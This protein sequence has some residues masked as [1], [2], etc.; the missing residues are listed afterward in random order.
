MR[1]RICL[2]VL[3]ACLLAGIVSGC[4]GR[5]VSPA[6]NEPEQSG[7]EAAAAPVRD[8][9][10]RDEAAATLRAQIRAGKYTEVKP[11]AEALLADFPGDP[12]VKNLVFSSTDLVPYEGK[13]EHIFFH[14]LIAYKERALNGK[15][16][17]AGQDTY[18]VTVKEFNA[19]IAQMYEN[20]Y[21]LTSMHDLFS[22]T[23]NPDGTVTGRKKPV[24]LPRGKKPYIL[25]IDDMNYYEYMIEDGQVWKLVFDEN[26]EVAAY[27]KNLD[28][29]GEVRR[30]NA[31][32][33]LIDD[34]CK[35]HPDANFNGAKGLIG[36][37]GYE[38]VLGYRTNSIRYDNYV[39]EQQAVAPI[40]KK[41]KETGWDFASHSQGHRHTN[42]ASYEKIREDTDRWAFEVE[43][44]VGKTPIYIYPFG[45]TVK[46][47]DPKLAYFRKM[48]F[49]IFCGVGKTPYLEE[50]KAGFLKMDRRAI[51]GT[52][53]KSGVNN[54][55]L[56]VSRIIDKSFRKWA[57]N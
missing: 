52:T 25:S 14:P 19:T 23:T 32:V 31:I 1:K 38:G 4:S 41:L 48:G 55:L 42:S 51:D 12:V 54:N 45:E 27:A 30:D 40:I 5:H 24:Y 6:E 47:N 13:I 20:G 43:P 35:A 56:D 16:N 57:K 39:A 10:Y 17:D 3:T 29:I 46:D 50:T 36:L 8:L 21:V 37:T 49:A 9:A 28:G 34:F 2:L 26:G 33:P 44:L 7:A 11:L 18:M 15:G 53:L 22:F